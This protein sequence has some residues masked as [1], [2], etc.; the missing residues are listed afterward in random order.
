M[1]FLKK[2]RFVIGIFLL[3]GIFYFSTR[4]YNLL[5]I[6]IFTDEAI[7][8]RWAQ[9]A[10]NDANWR[11]ISLTDGKQPLFIWLEMLSM[12]L[13]D[14]PLYAGRFVSVLAGFGT[15]VGL[16]FLT[17]EVFKNKYIALLSSFL[18]VIFPMSLVYDKMALYDSLVGTFAVWGLFGAILLTKTIRL[19]VALLLGMIMGAGVLNKTNGFTTLYLLPFTLLLFNFKK[20]GRIRRFLK[21]V[22]LAIVATGITYA[23]YSILRLSP[24]FHIISEKNA[25]FIYPLQEWIKHPFNYFV[26]NISALWDWFWHYATWSFITLLIAS[27]VVTKKFLRE[28]VL[29]F[30]WFLIPFVGFGFL[31]N[32]IYPRYILYMVLPLIP[33]VAL[34]VFELKKKIKSTVVYSIVILVLLALPLYSDYLIFADF[35][36]SPIPWA[37][38]TQYNLDWPAGGGVKESVEFFKEKAKSGKIYVATSGTFGLMPYSYEI[39]LWDNK[40]IKIKGFWPMG[41]IP[42]QEVLEIA[43]KIPAYYVFYQP[44]HQCRNIGGAP[45]QWEPYLE[46]ETRYSKDPYEGKPERYL[47]VYRVVPR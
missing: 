26:G 40:N 25:I 6:P 2:Y 46:L 4:I 35:N 31:G 27:F 30:L 45:I 9:I 14:D 17:W 11:F 23:M 18:Y 28:K 1:E 10:K 34:S 19:D 41:D 33:L 43:K 29:L 7:Y 24:F 15:M 39:Y 20:E 36:H 8:V 38:V 13:F 16:F 47:S 22:G 5:A 44:C 37:D 42:P 21:W 32:N 3:L 12:R